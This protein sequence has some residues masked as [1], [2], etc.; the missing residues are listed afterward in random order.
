MLTAAHVGAGSFALG[1]TTYLSTGTVFTNFTCNSI[2]ADLTL[3]QINGTPSLTNLSLANPASGSTV[4]MIGFG[5][6]KSWANNTIYAY[7]NYTLSDTSYGGP[8]VITLASGLGNSGGQGVVGDS[9]G[10]L[11]YQSSGTWY[12]TGIFS[13]TGDFTSGS[14]NLGMGTAAVD[15]AVYVSQINDDLNSVSAIPKPTVC[16]AFCGAGVFF[17]AIGRRRRA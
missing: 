17:A 3:F 14:T 11:F 9:G 7:V 5:G 8:G 10:G 13:G 15:L 12:L 1:N 4:Q 2:V 16:A 6:G